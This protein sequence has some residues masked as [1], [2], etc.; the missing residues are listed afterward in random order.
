M[1]SKRIIRKRQFDTTKPLR[2]FRT[3]DELFHHTSTENITDA[4]IIDF[5]EQERYENKDKITAMF[6]KKKANVP[7]P[8]INKSDRK[9]KGE[10][11]DR[12]AATELSILNRNK[13][14]DGA[15]EFIYKPIRHLKILKAQQAN[16][17]IMIKFLICFLFYF[18]T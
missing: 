4:N 1:K 10:F 11:S 3:F 9:D 5:V 8:D 2:L 15:V 7:I 17:V 16:K 6:D 13:D 18:D 12:S 14:D